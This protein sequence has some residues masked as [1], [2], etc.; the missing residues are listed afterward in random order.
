MN[1]N[2]LIA[3]GIIFVL[4]FTAFQTAYIDFSVES[5]LLQVLSMAAVIIGAVVAIIMFNKGESS[6]H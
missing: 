3:L 2:K 4:I 5:Q 6:H 1:K